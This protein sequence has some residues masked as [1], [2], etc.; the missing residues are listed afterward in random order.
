MSSSTDLKTTALTDAHV[1]QGARMV[2]F[3]GYSMPVQYRDGVLKE[4]LWTRE[5]AGAFDVSHM[6][7]AS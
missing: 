7:P 5:H 6:G 1:A 4:H 3:A 2:E